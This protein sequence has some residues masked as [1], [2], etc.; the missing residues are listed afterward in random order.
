M[1]ITKFLQF[2]LTINIVAVAITVIGAAFLHRSPLGAVQMLWVNLIMDSLASLALATESPT[3]ALLKLPP[4]S[5][6]A[7]LL[8]SKVLKHI[9]G[10]AVYQVRQLA[11]LYCL[12]V[13]RVFLP[14]PSLALTIVCSP[15]RAAAI[16]SAWAAGF[17]KLAAGAGHGGSRGPAGALHPRL[18]LAGPNELV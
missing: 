3:D 8:T 18:Q 15:S 6:D 17:W 11:Q 2:Q 9:A 13:D 16:R 10:Q 4:F 5:A 14:S 7:P 12:Y 1:S